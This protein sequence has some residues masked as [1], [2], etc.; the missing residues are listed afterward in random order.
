MA[1][2]TPITPLVGRAE[3]IRP[4]RRDGRVRGMKRASAQERRYFRRIAAANFRL[5]DGGPPASLAEM[6]DRLEDMQ[7]RQGPL[8]GAGTGGPHSGDLESHLAYLARLRSID[9]AYRRVK[10]HEDEL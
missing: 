2:Y 9:P 5:D 6:F 10:H 7:R 8:G 4:A 1:A 3:P